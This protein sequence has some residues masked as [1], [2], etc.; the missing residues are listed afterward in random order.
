MSKNKE[1]LDLLPLDFPEDNEHED[2]LEEEIEEE[3]IE[4]LSEESDESISEES[5]YA[6]SEESSEAIPE[7]SDEVAETP[8]SELEDE[9]I[10]QKDVD[11]KLN[12]QQSQEQ[13]ATPTPA[14]KDKSKTI[15]IQGTF[16]PGQILQEG[17]VRADLSIEQVAQETKINK[18]YIISL[19]M[20][21][22]ENLPQGI[23]VEAYVKQLC[24]V[25]RLDPAHVLN[26]MEIEGITY[27]DK[28]VPG[29]ILHDIEKGKQ[30]NFQEEVRVRKF[31][32]IVGVAIVVLIAIVWIIIKINS[33]P[34][35]NPGGEA[36]APAGTDLSGEIVEVQPEKSIAPEEL[37]VFLAP[38]SF[39][40]T[41]L[42]VPK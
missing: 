29:E 36:V 8:A 41:E 27:E 9:D 12:K 4:D 34:T 22:Q 40:M 2:L 3:Q 6:I 23:Y 33:K 38:Q 19:E 5:D 42:K 21:D 39:T 10:K 37:E 24:K 20:G 25:Y 35:T 16:L 28:K 1:N 11:I 18:K 14:K 26:S 32:K 7:N 15:P 17:R 30:V 31:F 13:V